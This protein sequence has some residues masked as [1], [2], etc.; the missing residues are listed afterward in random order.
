MTCRICYICGREGLGPIPGLIQYAGADDI[1]IFMSEKAWQEGS[2]DLLG[3]CDIEK[4][5]TDNNLEKRI[6]KFKPDVILVMTYLKKLPSSLSIHA[7]Y[8]MV[9]IH[10]SLLPKY[11]GGAPVFYSM[12][13]GETETGVTFHFMSEEFDQGDIINQKKVKVL[14]SDCASSVAMK[15]N[16]KIISSLPEWLDS[17]ENWLSSAIKQDDSKATYVGF[18]SIV[19][20]SISTEKTCS[21]NLNII[22]ACGRTKGAYIMNSDRDV[23]ITIAKQIDPNQDRLSLW[24]KKNGDYAIFP[25]A[26]GF[27]ALEEGIKDSTAIADWAFFEESQP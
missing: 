22:R 15:I 17:R 14:S 21:D 16:R 12:L 23:R 27:I 10:P 6:E 2:D 8:G 9:N 5:T 7:K 24:N 13:N 26:D 1:L 11:R 20:M 4:I 25:A 19:E 18:P 3:K